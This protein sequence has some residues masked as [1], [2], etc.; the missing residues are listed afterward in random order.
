MEDSG[1]IDSLTLVCCMLIYCPLTKTPILF[2]TSTIFCASS[3]QKQST[4]QK[5]LIILSR[6]TSLIWAIGAIFSS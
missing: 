2:A 4:K 3:S 6:L 1:W 5:S